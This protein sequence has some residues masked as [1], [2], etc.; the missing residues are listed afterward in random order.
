MK[1]VYHQRAKS[2]LWET[3]KYDFSG[4]RRFGVQPCKI[5]KSKHF[6]TSKEAQ[7]FAK[8]YLKNCEFLSQEF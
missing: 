4:A 1:A 5:V 6:E 2:L 7:I 8:R 3:N